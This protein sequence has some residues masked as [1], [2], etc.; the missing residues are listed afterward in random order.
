MTPIGFLWKILG[1]EQTVSWILISPQLN[2]FFFFFTKNVHLK[3]CVQLISACLAFLMRKFSR[4][5]ISNRAVCLVFSVLYGDLMRQQLTLM[6]VCAIAAE[7]IPFLSFTLALAASF[8]AFFSLLPFSPFDYILHLCRLDSESR[9]LV[10][11]WI[12]DGWSRQR[13]DLC[14]NCHAILMTAIH[15]VKW[16]TCKVPAFRRGPWPVISSL[17]GLYEWSAY[18]TDSL[19]YLIE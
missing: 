15:A 14:E 3:K 8:I 19:Y 18:H 13:L 2:T 4:S 1:V 17:F 7:P 12:S 6:W 5:R 9:S 10:R 16:Q 11:R